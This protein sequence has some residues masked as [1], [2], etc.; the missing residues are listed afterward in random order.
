MNA[1][2]SSARRRFRRIGLCGRLLLLVA[3]ALAPL[4]HV[5][6]QSAPEPQR[7]ELLNGLRVLFWQR[8]S[9]QQVFIKLRVHS[10]AAFDTARSISAG[11]LCVTVATF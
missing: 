11:G 6:A 4:L 8:P 7:E 5:A 9:D 10:G 3:C 1:Q 2:N